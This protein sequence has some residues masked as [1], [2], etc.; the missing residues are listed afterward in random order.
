[1]K[2]PNTVLG[3]ERATGS[4][5]FSSVVM[6]QGVEPEDRELSF[7]PASVLLALENVT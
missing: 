4:F 7:N 3:P 6:N 5:L 2:A 1:M